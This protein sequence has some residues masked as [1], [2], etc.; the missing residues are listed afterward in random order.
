M[1]MSGRVAAAVGF[2]SQYVNSSLNGGSKCIK[3]LK[4]PI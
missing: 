4:E 2:I 3:S 1:S